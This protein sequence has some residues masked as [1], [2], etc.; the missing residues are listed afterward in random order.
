MLSQLGEVHKTSPLRD[1]ANGDFRPSSDGAAPN[2]GVKVFVPWAL[3]G[4]VGEWNFYHTGDNPGDII[5][6]HW[7]MTD[8]HVSREGYHE[9]PM[10]PL[11]GVNVNEADY[12]QGP[13]ENWI[14]G[15]LKFTATKK[16]YATLSN[17]DLMKPFSF[18]DL[19]LSR[20]ENARPESFTIEGAALQNPQIHDSSVL[21][22]IYFQTAA[23]HTGGVLM[24]KMEGK[25]YSLAIAASGRLSFVVKGTG[26]SAAVE[27]QSI[28]N[29]GQWH[30][31]IVEA[32]RRTKALTVY[33][34]GRK[35]ASAVGVDGSVSLANEGDVYVGGTP[36]GR[37]L[38]GTLDFLRIARGTLEDADTTIEELYAWE[39]D[40]PCFRDFTGRKLTG[41]R[42]NAGAISS[43]P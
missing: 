11:K 23:G 42:R 3:S 2:E 36:D 20:H 34:D 38:D 27:S 32:D 12:V 26:A 15:A 24:E 30:H 16:Q 29:D 40:G 8:Y 33:V 19:K 13:L 22:E 39:F 31:A 10:Y 25:G 4:V 21:I 1:P 7:Y 5:D 43:S 17:A 9:R 14:S 6:E 28:I 37:F 18:R 41:T 35:D